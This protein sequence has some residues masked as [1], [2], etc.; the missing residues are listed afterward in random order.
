MDTQDNVELEK[1]GEF[2]LTTDY[3]NNQYGKMKPDEAASVEDLYKIANARGYKPG[4]AY[5]N[6]KRMGMLGWLDAWSEFYK[7]KKYLE[8]YLSKQ[9]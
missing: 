1:V 6:A 3:K 8:G 5:M 9:R 7:S 4:W 2:K